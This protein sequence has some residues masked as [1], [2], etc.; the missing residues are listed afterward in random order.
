M[1]QSG[2]VLAALEGAQIL[3]LF[4]WVG[5]T[6]Y[7]RVFQD[8]EEEAG[9]TQTIVGTLAHG[10]LIDRFDRATGCGRFR[11]PADS[12]AEEG[13]HLVRD[14]ISEE[15]FETMPRIEPGVVT[16]SNCNG[17]AGWAYGEIRWILQSHEFG[18]VDR[19]NWSRK[20]PTK[21]DIAAR[22]FADDPNALFD[23]TELGMEAPDAEF[24]GTTLVLAHAFNRQTGAYEMHLGRSRKAAS[25][26][27]GPWHWRHRVASGGSDAV[28]SSMVG[29]STGLPGTAAS[30]EVPDLPVRLRP[31]AASPITEQ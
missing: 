9:H 17:S 15:A 29:W 2:E 8:Y 27:G 18:R 26:E 21:Q 25:Q 7:G 31:A 1:S 28:P 11:L 14:G 13:L 22:P 23:Y 12:P 4:D 10:Y 30:I 20:S 5:R 16:R 6:V 24:T 19:I 3:D